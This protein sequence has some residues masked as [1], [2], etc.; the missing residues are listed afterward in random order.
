[1]RDYSRAMIAACLVLCGAVGSAAPSDDPGP[2]AGARPRKPYRPLDLR[3]EV[4]AVDGRSVTVRGF[5]P[6]VEPRPRQVMDPDGRGYTLVG[7]DG[8]LVVTLGGVAHLCRSAHV[9]DEVWTLTLANGDIRPV[10]RRD[11]PAREFP[12]DEVLAAGGFSPQVTACSSYRLSDVR[13][14]DLVFIEVRYDRDEPVCW[15]I[16]IERRPGGRVPVAPGQK[17]DDNI[18]HHE[19]MN[20][21]QDW[22]ER[23]IPLPDKYKYDPAAR[24]AERDARRQEVQARLAQR[25]QRAA[26]RL[27]PPPREVK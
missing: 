26:D 13:V 10:R 24:Q 5:A 14:G 2:P 6:L 12:A 1:M 3:G 7:Q 15:A 20:T 17:P 16:S 19:V 11:M 27:A 22:E 23:G 4:T 25:A 8:D 9:T 21:Y 18:K